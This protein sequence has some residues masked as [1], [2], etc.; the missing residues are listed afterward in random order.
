[1]RLPRGSRR[2]AS[3][4]TSSENSEYDDA[5]NEQALLER[6]IAQLEERLRRATVVDE[7]QIDT[8]TVGVGVARPR[9]GPEVGRLEEVPDRRLDRGQPGRE[10]ALQRVADRQGAGRPQARRRRHRRGAAR[11]QAQA[12]DHQDRSRIDSLARWASPTRQS[13][14]SRSCSRSGVRSWR[15]CASAGVEPFPHAF[16]GRTDIAVVRAAHEGLAGGEE[17]DDRYRVAGRVAARRGHGKAAFIDLVDGSRPDSAAC[18]RRTSSER[19]RSR[20]WS[21]VDLGDIIGAEGTVFATKRGE[22]SLRVDGWA[23]LAKSLRPPPD[24]FHGLEDVELRYRHRELDLIAN[25]EVREL[26]T[27]RAQVVT[28]V[29][30]WLDDAR[31]RRGRDAG[32]PA[33]LRRRAR[34]AF[35]DPSQRARPRPLPADRHRAL[36]EALHRR[37]DRPRLRARQGLPQRGH[38]AQAQPRVHDARVVRGLRRLHRRGRAAGAA[39]RLGRGVRLRRRRRSSATADEIDLSAALA[40]DHAARRDQG[41][42]RARP[43]RASEPRGARRRDGLRAGAGRRAGGSSSTAC[44]RS[45]SSRP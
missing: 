44:C 3:S 18:P 37:R 6:R 14:P 26:F 12:Q 38:L 35:H 25:P 9:Q 43:R 30:E 42:H 23:L 21:S 29:R 22:L 19:R 13:A 5:K 7:R 34:A 17:T 16:E 31:L 33:A 32:A 11:P 4:A 27:K 10:Q 15:G 40:A 45:W 41:P 24:K 39:R 20:P 36:P 1:M 2:R 28:A 8:D